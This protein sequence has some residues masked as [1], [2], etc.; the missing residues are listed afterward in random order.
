MR[1]DRTVNVGTQAGGHSA[2][3]LVTDDGVVRMTAAAT[4]VFLR[5][6]GAKHAHF[7]GLE[8]GLA[9]DVLL[10]GPAFF[11][12]YQL[13]GGKAAY[14]LLEDGHVFGKPRWS[15]VAHWNP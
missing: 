13:F 2:C 11:M 12:G 14:R 5:D 10:L 15:V 4:A 3:Q 6:T 8:P 7:T 1:T 9:V